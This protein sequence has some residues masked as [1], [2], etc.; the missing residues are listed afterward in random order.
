MMM[1]LLYCRKNKLSS[2]EIKLH[3]KALLIR[4]NDEFD[5]YWLFEYE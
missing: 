3:D 4:D 2:L 5:E 1:A